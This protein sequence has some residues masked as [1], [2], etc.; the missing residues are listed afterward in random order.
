MVK[1]SKYK[2]KKV[3]IDGMT[4]DSM[5]EGGVYHKLKLMKNAG[6]VLDFQCQVEMP[7]K[8]NG[9]KMFRYIA[10]FEVIWKNGNT[11]IWDVKSSFT[12]KNPVYRLK[13]KLIEEQYKIKIEEV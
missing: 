13:K 9:K 8:L 6:E 3:L 10:D 5:K 12:K 7:F 2:N 1:Q 11:E 4:F